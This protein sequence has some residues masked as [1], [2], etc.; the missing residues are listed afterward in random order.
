MG[1]MQSGPAADGGLRPAFA[2]VRERLGLVLALVGLAGVGWGWTVT[3]MQ[4][5]DDGPWTALGAFSWFIGAGLA[6]AG[7]L[8]LSRRG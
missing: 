2:A 6:F 3:Q 7:Y 4:G 8:A 5:M 1:G